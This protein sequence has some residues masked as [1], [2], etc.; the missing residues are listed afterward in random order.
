MERN[1]PRLFQ[2]DKQLP[3]SEKKPC[4]DEDSRKQKLGCGK[5]SRIRRNFVSV[6]PNLLLPK[7]PLCTKKRQKVLKDFFLCSTYPLKRQ[8]RS[9]LI[10]NKAVT[11]IL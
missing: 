4:E 1:I 7:F 9:S 11:E 8:K 5:R 2:G 3:Q 10:E 6:T